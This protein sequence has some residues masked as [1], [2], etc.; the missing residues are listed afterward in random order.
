[1]SH[2]FDVLE[3]EGLIE[4]GEVNEAKVYGIIPLTPV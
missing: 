2:L 4:N 1:M 3:Y